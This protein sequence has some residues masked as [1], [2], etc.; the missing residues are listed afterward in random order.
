M[1]Y[2]LYLPA[3]L[4]DHDLTLRTTIKRSF[5]REVPDWAGVNRVPDT[6]RLFIKYPIGEAVLLEK[7]E[8]LELVH[9]NNDQEYCLADTRGVIDEI[10]I[11]WGEESLGL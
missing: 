11:A 3:A 2:Y 4:I 5:G 9:D 1:G 7:R 10:A 6:D 8:S